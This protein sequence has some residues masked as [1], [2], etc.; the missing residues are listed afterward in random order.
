MTTEEHK[1]HAE[2]C[3]FCKQKDQS[4]I[5]D[6]SVQK[7]QMG[8]FGYVNPIWKRALGTITVGVLIILAF[9]V[10]QLQTFFTIDY[11][12]QVCGEGQVF[13]NEAGYGTLLGT[14]IKP[15]AL[16]PHEGVNPNFSLPISNT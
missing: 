16:P 8:W 2:E 9:N 4:Q 12:N 14:G 6:H 13:T 15:I 3:E 10:G 5:L 11:Y 1:K 7:E